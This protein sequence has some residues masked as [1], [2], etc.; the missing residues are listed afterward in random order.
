MSE[1]QISPSCLERDDPGPHPV[2]AT[3]ST[4]IVEQRHTRWKELATLPPTWRRMPSVVRLRKRAK[5]QR[6]DRRSHLI[7][8]PPRTFFSSGVATGDLTDTAGSVESWRVLRVV[9]LIQS[10]IPKGWAGSTHRQYRAGLSGER[11]CFK[12]DNMRQNIVPCNCGVVIFDGGARM[13]QRIVGLG[14]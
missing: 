3:R 14:W 13:D 2:L 8:L 6:Q 9:G 4:S 1:W 7:P 12:T 10:L 5:V 11:I